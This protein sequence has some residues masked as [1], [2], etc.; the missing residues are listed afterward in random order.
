VKVVPKKTG[1]YFI[2]FSIE[3]SQAKKN[4]WALAYG[5]K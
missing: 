3:Q 1:T 5:Y 2:V 4:R